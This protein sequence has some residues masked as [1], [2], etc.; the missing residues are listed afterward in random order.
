MVGFLLEK[1]ANP[2]IKD[3]TGK[4]S[5]DIA[6]YFK[7]E[8][9]VNFLQN[10]KK[11][12]PKVVTQVQTNPTNDFLFSFY[13]LYD[14]NEHPS[15]V[16]LLVCPTMTQSKLSGYDQ[17]FFKSIQTKDLIPLLKEFLY[18]GNIKGGDLDLLIRLVELSIDVQF[19]PL[20]EKCY[21][22]IPS[23]I[24]IKNF[25]KPMKYIYDIEKDG[26]EKL[27]QLFVT[28]YLKN[29]NVVHIQD[30]KMKN[31]LKNFKEIKINTSS[32]DFTKEIQKMKT[33][34][35]Q[36][37]ELSDFIIISSDDKRMKVHQC[38]ISTFDLFKHFYNQE[39]E[40][41]DFHSKTLTFF[42]DLIYI[43]K[44]SLKDLEM[45][46]LLEAYTLFDQ[47]NLKVQSN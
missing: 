5:L 4:D 30:I 33:K 44:S 10:Y 39:E 46:H 8:E 23:L 17:V 38:I 34:I 27:T 36:T 14:T 20:E 28:F 45:N 13:P 37:K 24:T 1:N 31:F 18:T 12:P 19:L 16:S 22:M 41:V 3:K 29:E 47:C 6:K 32:I 15:K 11:E 42:L 25:E 7:R 21:S 35:Y 2:L 43:G 26:F 40:K 9:V